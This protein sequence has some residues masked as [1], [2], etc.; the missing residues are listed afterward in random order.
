MIH[1]IWV[2]DEPT[3][4]YKGI[5]TIGPDLMRQGHP[6][7]PITFWCLDKDVEHY[8]T[9]FDEKHPSQAP[10]QVRGI[11]HYISTQ[12][13]T[14]F[15]Y[16]EITLEDDVG[17]NYM[18][19]IFKKNLQ[20]EREK[21]AG[22]TET[23]SQRLENRTVNLN[24]AF[25]V[26]VEKLKDRAAKVESFKPAPPEDKIRVLK[27][28]ELI[29]IKD[30]F[31]YFLQIN[32]EGY[33]ADT[34]VFPNLLSKDPL[35]DLGEFSASY[36][37]E[38]GRWKQRPDPFIMFCQKG[39]EKASERFADY[40]RNVSYLVGLCETNQSGELA[41]CAQESMMVP[42]SHDPKVRT[43]IT[44]QFCRPAKQAKR[45]RMSADDCRYGDLMS[46]QEIGLDKAFNN[47]HKKSQFNGM[48]IL[49]RVL[50]RRHTR[51]ELMYYLSLEDAVEPLAVYHYPS[52]AFTHYLQSS[53]FQEASQS[54]YC[55]ADEIG[56]LLSLSKQPNA[57]YN[58]F[59]YMGSGTK[60]NQSFHV[61]YNIKTETMGISQKEAMATIDQLTNITDAIFQP[62]KDR[63]PLSDLATLTES[64]NQYGENESIIKALTLFFQ[65]GPINETS[66]P[67]YLD[68]FERLHQAQAPK[69][70]DGQPHRMFDP[71]PLSTFDRETAEAELNEFISKHTK[72]GGTT[73]V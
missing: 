2:G 27:V 71:P 1:Y 63:E 69:E 54:R 55:S 72:T 51:D 14:P 31:S 50:S 41:Y 42:I 9:Y 33:I 45:I 35:P 38:P 48:P 19:S 47:S 6:E 46:S 17:E 10:I 3:G 43:L 53:L 7:E 24:Q 59:Q 70:L 52:S 12:T 18:L 16:P 67:L 60:A 8:Q 23:D 37:G 40:L 56:H 26:L 22:A 29:T 58:I 20:A 11:E 73:L 13:E 49:H 34:S 36:T 64:L 61:L 21:Q 4:T 65:L 62:K 39:D 15:T 68:A 32:E 5:D 44:D 30:A 57:F 25:A 28:Q 66:L